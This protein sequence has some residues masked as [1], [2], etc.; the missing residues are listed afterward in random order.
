M[1]VQVP[2]AQLAVPPAAPDHRVWAGPREKPA[3]EERGK[4]KEGGSAQDTPRL[5]PLDDLAPPKEPLMERGGSWGRSPAGTGGVEEGVLAAGR[6][7]AALSEVFIGL[8]LSTAAPPPRP[9][10]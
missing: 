2:S 4:E 7:G 9:P 5:V 1:V 8:M 3:G 6:S 10:L